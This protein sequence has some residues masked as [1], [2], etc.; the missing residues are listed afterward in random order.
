MGELADHLK[1][2]D[3][4][5]VANESRP[6]PI[7]VTKDV[8]RWC[9]RTGQLA[10]WRIGM[11]GGLGSTSPECMAGTNGNHHAACPG[12]FL[13]P[14]PEPDLP[15]RLVAASRGAQARYGEAAVRIACPCS[16]HW[17]RLTINMR[18]L[19]EATSHRGAANRMWDELLQRE[20]AALSPSERCP[21]CGEW[22][23]HFGLV[24]AKA[25]PPTEERGAP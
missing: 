12:W 11:V 4:V 10:N 9:E 13:V 19:D 20:L 15:P 5:V 17:V 7:Q 6:D 3:P 1:H 16:C 2:D 25:P 14:E 8:I 24:C 23:H 21:A 22:A 18:Q